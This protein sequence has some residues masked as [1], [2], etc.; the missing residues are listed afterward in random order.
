MWS[1]RKP[2]M[3][4]KAPTVRREWDS[5]F[6]KAKLYEPGAD[7]EHLCLA[8]SKHPDLDHTCGHAPR[9]FYGGEETGPRC[10]KTWPYEAVKLKD[11]LNPQPISGGEG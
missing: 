5:G 1:F 6:C 7:H 3:V 11:R 2:P 8:S 9:K 10:C 4:E